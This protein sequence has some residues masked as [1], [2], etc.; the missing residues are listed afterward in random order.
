[1]ILLP[2]HTVLRPDGALL[3]DG[4]QVADLL[5]C[6]HCQFVWRVRPGSGRRRGFCTR[7]Q[8]VTCGKPACMECVPFKSLTGE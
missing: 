2:K 7:C 5:Q 8:G 3:E 1:M 4:R 6:V